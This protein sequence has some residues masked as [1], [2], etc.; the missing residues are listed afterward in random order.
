MR[1]IAAAT[2]RGDHGQKERYY[3][4]HTTTRRQKGLQNLQTANS[5]PINTNTFSRGKLLKPILYGIA[6]SSYYLCISAKTKP[7]EH[8][9]AYVL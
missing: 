9:R 8:Q 2:E 6:C 3:H 5:R 4:T 1:T 7:F